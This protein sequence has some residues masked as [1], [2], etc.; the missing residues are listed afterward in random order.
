VTNAQL[1]L[2]IGVPLLFNAGLIGAMMLYINSKFEG[3]GSKF[4]GVDARFDGINQRLDDLRDLWRSELRRVEEVLDAR[5]KH[6]EEQ[7][8]CASGLNFPSDTI[9]HIV[10]ECNARSRG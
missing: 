1:Y 9:R 4:E 8:N 5:L 7:T 3:V 6:L 10:I 2:A